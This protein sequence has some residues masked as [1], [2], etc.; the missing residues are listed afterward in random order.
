LND[1]KNATGTPAC[2]V[3]RGHLAHRYWRFS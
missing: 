2:A 1:A 3:A